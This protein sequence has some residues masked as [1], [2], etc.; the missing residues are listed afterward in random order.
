M[1]TQVTPVLISLAGCFVAIFA[2]AQG[3]AQVRA[4]LS[5]TISTPSPT[6]KV[7]SDLKID[8]ALTNT[9]HES[10]SGTP[11]GTLKVHDSNGKAVSEVE[12]PKP[13]EEVVLKD[14]SKVRIVRPPEGSHQIQTMLPG[15]THDELIANKFFDFSKPGT[16]TIQVSESF[17]GFVVNSNT[18]TVTVVPAQT[19]EASSG[20]PRLSVALSA[21]EKTSKAGSRVIVDVSLTNTSSGRVLLPGGG[22]EDMLPWYTIQVRRKDGT[23]VPDSQ[24][25]QARKRESAK[26]LPPGMFK[27][28]NYSRIAGEMQP[29]QTLKERV[30]LSDLYDMSEPGD[31]VVQAQRVEPANGA[32][33]KSTGPASTSATDKSNAD[34]VVKSNSIT[35]T[36]TP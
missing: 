20:K 36:V 35:L 11:N 19:V 7:G 28:D 33:L 22:G 5:V 9:S 21:V 13:E 16:Y 18:V 34:T 17:H 2:F 3:Q 32:V 15:T 29:G 6:I 27:V 31:Y 23:P 4:P 14:G 26:P 10:L 30:V 24:L 12:E 1:E 25:V 8:I